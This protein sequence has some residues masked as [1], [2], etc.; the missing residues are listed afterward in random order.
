MGELGGLIMIITIAAAVL[1]II[2]FFKIWA[3]CDDVKA[4]RGN[5]SLSSD[6]RFNIRKMILLGNKEKAKELILN[7]FFEAIKDVNYK[8]AES[9]DAKKYSDKEFLRIKKELEGA[10]LKIG[11]ELPEE[12]KNLNSGND[13]YCLYV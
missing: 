3:M 12:I 8:D 7:R 13:F 10:L 11:E 6:F 4:M 1:Q 9:D 2:L 5:F